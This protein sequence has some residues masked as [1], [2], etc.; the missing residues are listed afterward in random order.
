MLHINNSDCY[1]F[2]RKPSS[3]DRDDSPVLFKP[4]WA[5]TQK[6]SSK[7]CLKLL[8]EILQRISTADTN[9]NSSPSFAALKH[10]GGNA[11]ETRQSINLD[12]DRL[13]YDALWQDIMLNITKNQGARDYIYVTHSELD[14]LEQYAAD[15]DSGQGTTQ[16]VF[17]TCGHYFTKLSFV[18]ETERLNK[19]PALAGIKLP[20]TLSVIKQYYSRNN[21]MP[22]ACPRCVLGALMMLS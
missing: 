21:R 9:F 3:T 17:F 8:S 12:G 19:E 22:L 11:F 18:K 5:F 4:S 6:F 20:E 16:A 1:Y 13:P 2:Y 15:N 7:F 10:L 14:R